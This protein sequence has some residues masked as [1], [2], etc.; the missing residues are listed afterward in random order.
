VSRSI[1]IR[2]ELIQRV[3]L[4]V[5]HNG[6]LRKKDLAKEVGIAD[7]TLRNFLNGK[8]VDY[9]TFEGICSRLNLEWQDFASLD[10]SALGN[11]E[12]AQQTPSGFELPEKIAPVKNWVGR[13]QELE[14]LKARILDPDTRAITIT[15]VCVVGL[16]G[17]GKTALASQLVR[18]LQAEN[19]PF[20]AVAWESLPPGI[21]KPPRFDGIID[22]LLE[23]LS[24]GQITEAVTARDDYFKKTE[25]LL[26][27]LKAKPCLVILDNVETVLKTR[28][29]EGAGYF[30]DD[31]VE[32]AWLFQQ[33]AGT[34]HQSKV[35]FTSRETLAELLAKSP[36]QAI[37]QMELTGLALEAAVA[38]LQSFN[39]NANQEELE[40]LAKRYDRHPKALQL[41][42]G[43]ITNHKAFQ[44]RVGKFLQDKTWLLIRDIDSL[45]DEVIKRLSDQ[46]QACLCR[47]SVYKTQDYPL[48]F[49]GIAAQMPEVSEYDLQ[50]H[51]IT[52]LER[53]QLLDYDLD[54][55]SYQLHPLV[56]EKA[57]RL[58]CRDQESTRTA[59]RRAAEFYFNASGD[60]E[61][62]RQVKA[63]FEAFYHFYE[64][65]DFVKCNKALLFNIL[66]AETIEN[67]RCSVNLWHY[68]T[69]IVNMGKKILDNL[70]EKE[71]LMTLIPIAVCHVE[72][73]RNLKA[74]EIVREI[75]DNT[76]LDKQDA[77]IVFARMA[78][79]SIAG[80]ANRLI[81][82]FQESLQACEEASK[83]AIQCKYSQGKALTLYELGRTY[84]ELDKPGHA[85]RCFVVAAFQAVGSRVSED[86]YQLAGLLSGPIETLIPRIE[87][88]LNKQKT[89][90][91]DN[92]NIKK[93]RILYSLAQSF[94]SMKFYRLAEF[95]TMKALGLLETIDE[96][97]PTS[98]Y[99][100]LA[101]CHSGRGDQEKAS[102]YY[103][104][105]LEHL[106]DEDGNFVKAT[107]LSEVA[108]W[109]MQYGRYREALDK[110]K[111][112]EKL[113]L[114]TDFLY[115]KA[116]S[117]YGLSLSYQQLGYFA[118]ARENCAH[119]LKISEELKVSLAEEC[120]VLQ[121]QLPDN[122]QSG[123]K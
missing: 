13:S 71:K 12:N 69:R 42:A 72:V 104:K 98:S 23:K 56:Q 110:Y 17:I 44:G 20:V 40:E 102:H 113:L 30:A 43:Q 65:Q 45:I 25:R 80:K 90:N 87:K 96:S 22:S 97:T 5:K 50:E 35:I 100:E 37:H 38:L 70:S 64:I 58:L 54:R 123:D 28:Q 63:A 106:D 29:A 89:G 8:P 116:R 34:E 60:S 49:D 61:D 55:E 83:I 41:V 120:R 3:K 19:A 15:A 46:E 76:S 16:A 68:P 4:A 66:G 2:P 95:F 99:L 94:N 93:F 74:L 57:Y 9:A 85:I 84:L 48:S 119:A 101:T 33:L 11:V 91:T 92:E 24:N 86:I 10:D 81:G 105:A 108:D 27:L 112:L 117:Y 32:Y 107:V 103:Q 52:A 79:Y 73:G 53:R 39:L 111:E 21:G 26:K 36:T 7:S 121:R 88:I 77:N 59:H 109:H 14:D 47:I 18:Q 62:T 1:K 118:L 122:D 31:C 115:L 51:I 67:L 82:N 78:A 114:E 6:F 75:I